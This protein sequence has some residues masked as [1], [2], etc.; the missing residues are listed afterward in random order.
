[1]ANQYC[2]IPGHMQPSGTIAAYLQEILKLS[3][4]EV[5][6]VG[7]ALQA[8]L[9]NTTPGTEQY[10]VPSNEEL[11]VFSIHGYIRMVD[12]SSEPTAIFTFLN[13]DPSERWFVKT[14]NCNLKLENL[15]RSLQV[16]DNRDIPLGAISPPVGSP[17]YFPPQIPMVVPAGHKLK[18][19]FTLQD[20]GSDAVGGSTVYGVLLTGAL[21]PKR[22]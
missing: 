3:P 11:V 21:V 7:I 5:H 13:P 2:N 9:T 14:S 16:Y 15:D 12:F 22:P 10:Q 6:P 20:S 1:M 19:T 17:M 8:T 18:A 4:A